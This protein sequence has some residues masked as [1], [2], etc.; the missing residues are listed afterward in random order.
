M[1]IRKSAL[2][3]VLTTLSSQ[4]PAEPGPAP[5]PVL[6]DLAGDPLPSGAIARLGTTRYRLR[7]W[8]PR[9]HLFPDGSRLLWSAQD[10]TISIMDLETGKTIDSFRDPELSLFWISDLSP[11]GK[12]LIQ[13]GTERS[14]K[15]EFNLTLQLYNLTARKTIW[16]V[17][18]KGE[19]RASG[20][21]V[22]FTPDGKRILTFAQPGDI[23]VWD[24]ATG[25][26]L[27]RE[28]VPGNAHRFE[29]SPNGK[30]VALGY[31]DLHVWD[32]ESDKPP[33]KIN[34]GP[35]RTSFEQIQF[36]ADS[37]TIYVSGHGGV[38]PKG[39][40]IATGKMTGYLQF[41][42]RADWYSFSPD[43]KTVAFGRSGS[44]LDADDRTGDIIL[45]DRETKKEI[46]KLSAAPARPYGAMWSND[47]SRLVSIADHR[48][49]AFNVKARKLIGPSVAGHG[50]VVSS[51]AFAPDGRVYT[52][53]HDSA[54]RTWDIATGKLLAPFRVT[55]DW[56]PGLAVSPDGSL[57]AAS[58]LRNEFH[59]W[60]AKTGQLVF[61]LP[62]H[63]RTGG[64][65][66]LRFSADEQ[67]LASWGDDWTFRTFDALN[68][69]LRSEHRF[70]P[71]ELADEDEDSIRMK[72]ELG[73]G[74]PRV[75]EIAP[76]AKSIVVANGKHVFVYDARGKEQ[77]RIEAHP[78][79]VEK[80][81]LS[82][83]GK[84]L[85]TVG[86]GDNA[87]ARGQNETRE[88]QLTIWD[89]TTAKQVVQFPVPMKTWWSVLAFSR[90]GQ[91]LVTGSWEGTLSLWDPKTGKRTGTIELPHRA[92]CVGFDPSGKRI[93]VG[94]MDTTALV[95]D[96]KSAMKPAKE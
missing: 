18:P 81:T 27:R 86:S 28:S 59:V 10:K 82:A 72:M 46:G 84:W 92:G 79:G 40:D 12:R 70:L 63:G 55:S 54:V 34:M 83:D 21:G 35:L 24:A 13:F 94:L 38:A 93:V 1:V 88:D 56:V 2:I 30:T 62:G 71:S 32:W 95:F 96:L 11:D 74:D 17:R 80:L 69:K 5:R 16:K 44:R 91:S 78:R 64:V 85:A 61:N 42:D 14:E 8:L 19:Q 45:M 23:R 37:K 15:G 89:M 25:D 6:V 60:D 41:C 39:F 65:R 47:G 66:K 77:F 7:D 58:P 53:G 33:R 50:G 36:S 43:G 22:Q 49:C 3:L 87:P 57:V 26:E 29:L 4:A 20:A 73:V 52:S 48:I 76:D 67:T 9:Y 68:G 51:I 75:A 90:D 31:Y